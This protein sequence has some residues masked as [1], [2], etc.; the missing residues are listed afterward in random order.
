MTK[1]E[2][3][4]LLTDIWL[5]AGRQDR[6]CDNVKYL[7]GDLDKIADLIATYRKPRPDARMLAERIYNRLDCLPETGWVHGNTFLPANVLCDYHGQ[8]KLIQLIE[9]TINEAQP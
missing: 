5:R 8:Q 3:K 4:A 6:A 7:R 9:K 2:L 1:P